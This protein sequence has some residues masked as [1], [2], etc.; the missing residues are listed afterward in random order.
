MQLPRRL[1]Q[2]RKFKHEGHS[3]KAR[4][5]FT[6]TRVLEGRD[7]LETGKVA[8]PA[9]A[10]SYAR[11]TSSDVMEQPGGTSKKWRK[12][13]ASRVALTNQQGVR[14][15]PSQDK[16]EDTSGKRLKEQRTPAQVVRDLIAEG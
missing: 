12:S 3:L 16:A 13:L 10:K 8:L 2:T 11:M 14:G 9:A 5:L 4:E 7:D 6:R 15:F 1:N